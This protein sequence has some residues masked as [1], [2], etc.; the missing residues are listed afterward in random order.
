MV[1]K[2]KDAGRFP[3]TLFLVLLLLFFPPLSI[4]FLPTS[5]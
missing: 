5:P 2:F 1:L 4:P 3:L